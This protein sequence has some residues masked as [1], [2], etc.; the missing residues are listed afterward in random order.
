MQYPCDSKDDFLQCDL[1]VDFKSSMAHDRNE[2][3][4]KNIFVSLKI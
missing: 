3:L 2:M 4:A 1:K